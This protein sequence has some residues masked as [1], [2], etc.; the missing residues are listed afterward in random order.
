MLE[1]TLLAGPGPTAVRSFAT[2]LASV[3][4]VPAARVPL[5]T[6]AL[7]E[8]VSQWRQWLA[9]RGFGLG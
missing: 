7:H 6:G 8:A 3:M 1:L 4:E 2:C 5:P 9:A